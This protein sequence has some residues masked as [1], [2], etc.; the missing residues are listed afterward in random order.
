MRIAALSGC[1]HQQEH[2]LCYLQRLS[3]CRNPLCTTAKVDA[4]HPVSVCGFQSNA[5]HRKLHEDSASNR[6]LHKNNARQQA[7]REGATRLCT[8]SLGK[9]WTYLPS[10][11]LLTTS[12]DERASCSEIN[13]VRD[14][15]MPAPVD[16]V[17]EFKLSSGDEPYHKAKEERLM[18]DWSQEENDWRLC[19]RKSCA[20]FLP[21][22]LLN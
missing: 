4:T 21:F 11:N 22:R 8:Y 5:I 18:R 3:P 10:D 7:T 20:L 19:W 2:G 14:R 15:G 9:K 12:V 1:S 6:R 17:R 16:S 13:L